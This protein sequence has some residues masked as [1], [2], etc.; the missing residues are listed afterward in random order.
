M[1]NKLIDEDT[2]EFLLTHDKISEHAGT[3]YQRLFLGAKHN[4][5]G[6]ESY[7]AVCSLNKIPAACSL[8]KHHPTFD[9]IQPSY[10]L[11]LFYA[12][13][14]VFPVLMFCFILYSVY[15]QHGENVEVKRSVVGWPW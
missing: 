3:F 4:P 11:Q 6:T 10:A 2:G 5:E 7:I 13:Y 8:I 14:H 15:L 1:I 12:L 9:C